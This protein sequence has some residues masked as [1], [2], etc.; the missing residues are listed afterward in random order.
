MS[1]TAIN[2]TEYSTGEALAPQQIWE[3]K[4]AYGKKEIIM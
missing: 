4:V 2:W 1:L 3:E